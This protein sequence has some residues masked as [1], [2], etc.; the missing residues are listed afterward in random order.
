MNKEILAVVEAVSDRIAVLYFGSVVEEGRAEEIFAHPR[1]PYTKLLAESAPVVGRA[2][3]DP[4]DG[5]AELP[6]PLDPPP[7]CAFAMRCP[8]ATDQCRDAAPALEQIGDD[9][10]VACYHPLPAGPL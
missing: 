10:R 5:H 1:H 9:Q 7:G 8:Y 4:E 3:S 2:L 6:N